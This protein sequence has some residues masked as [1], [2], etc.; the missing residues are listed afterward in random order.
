MARDLP[1][2]GEAEHA[3]LLQTARRSLRDM[4]DGHPVDVPA[5]ADGSPL[6]Q[7]NGVFVTLK[8]E[9]R[10]R[11]CIGRIVGAGP[12]PLSVAELARSAAREDPRFPPLRSEELDDLHIE[13]TVLSPLEVIDGPE[14]IEVGRHGLVIEQGFQRGLLLPQVADEQGW[15]AVTFLEHTCLKAGLPVDAWQHG[16]KLSRFEAVFFEEPT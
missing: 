13:V 3:E 10:L 8:R 7:H 9:Q 4:I 2:L 14:Q 15:D 16:A 1:L 6:S 11:G 5:P 12:L